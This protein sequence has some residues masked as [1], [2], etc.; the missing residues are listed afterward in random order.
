MSINISFSYE[1]ANISNRRIESAFPRIVT[2]YNELLQKTEKG[3]DF[4]GWLDLPKNITEEELDRIEVKAAHL[5]S[6]SEVVV[7]IG[8]GGSYLGTRAVVELLS[9]HFDIAEQESR[10]APKLLYAGNHLSE[11]YLSDLLTFLDKKEYSLIVI[12]KSGTTTEPAIAFRILREHCEKKY[13]VKE[14][15]KRI[16]A[17]TDARRGALKELSTQKGYDTFVIP[18][19]VG[20]RYSVLSPVG[21]LPVATAGFSIR[22]LLKGACNMRRHA[23]GRVNFYSN[24]PTQYAFFRYLLYTGK[25]KIELMVAYEPR[26]YCFIEWFKQLFGESE[27]KEHK[28]I[29]PAGAIFSTDLHSLGQY[30]Q[31]GERIMFETVLS[32]LK[33]QK[34]VPIPFDRDDPDTLN[35]LHHRT[36]QEINQ[37]AEEGTRMAHVAGGVPNFRITIPEINPETVGEL[38][39]FFEFSCALSGYMLQVNPFDQPGVEAYKKNMFTL[40]GK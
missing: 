3:N 8:I 7:V 37:I 24:I 27:G 22:Q 15:I 40:L 23:F 36:I 31:D 10:K 34:H 2:A 33:S 16:V 21:L 35:Y 11:D 25:K 1:H 19:D 14:S 18:D 20:G 28:G 12:S 26:F 29:F 39:Y 13:G 30:I 6:I 5:A 17:V 32:V 4:L 9:P 38:I